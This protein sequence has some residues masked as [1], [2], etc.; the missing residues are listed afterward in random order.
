VPLHNFF[1][2]FGFICGTPVASLQFLAGL[3]FSIPKLSRACASQP[4]PAFMRFQY[5]S[6]CR[7]SLLNF[8]HASSLSN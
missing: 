3:C 8:L 6:F 4:L 1:H 5:L 2:S 7:S